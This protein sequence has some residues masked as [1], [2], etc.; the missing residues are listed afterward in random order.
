MTRRIQVSDNVFGDKEF[1]ASRPGFDVDTSTSQEEIAISSEWDKVCRVHKKAVL[2]GYGTITFDPLGYIPWADY[3]RIDGNRLRRDEVRVVQNVS[4]GI[5]CGVLPLY[6]M[7][8]RNTQI[9]IFEPVTK[10]PELYL[11]PP[12]SYRG[13]GLT[14]PQFLVIVYRLKAFDLRP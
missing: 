14:N 8:V 13:G 12:F 5:E 7:E 1:R 2:N 6:M 10:V 4:S 11:L 9:S 3:Y